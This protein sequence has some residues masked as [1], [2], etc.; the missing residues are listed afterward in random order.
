MS[1]VEFP[2][3]HILVCLGSRA[4]PAG[5][6]GFYWAIIKEVVAIPVLLIPP[7]Q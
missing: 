7:E 4:G 1:M 3:L 5:F 6:V 2:N